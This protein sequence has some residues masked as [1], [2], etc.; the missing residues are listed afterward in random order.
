MHNN[1]STYSRW[2]WIVAILLALGLVLMW[3]TGHGPSSTCCSSNPTAMP[4]AIEAAA[5]SSVVTPIVDSFSFK[6][7]A[8]EFSSV[9]DGSSIA[10]LSLSNQIKALLAEGKD[11]VASGDAN[12]I[13]L[14]GTI[15][16]E[17]AKQQ[18]TE[19][20]QALFGPNINIDNQMLVH[21][22]EAV[23]TATPPELAKFYFETAKA[24]LPSDYA[25]TLEPI[26]NW[27]K[28]NE[29]AKAVIS[30]FHDATGHA[31]RNIK[32]AKR[33]AQSTYDALITAGIDASRI[34]MRKPQEAI[35][36]GSDDEARRVEISIE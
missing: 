23:A 32:L 20:A 1:H 8:S 24:N 33:R 21:V 4:T 13:T 31:D 25:S 19:K 34:E 27:L 3:L 15:S 10:W 11:W 28:A 12:N 26:I 9:G 18:T 35:G 36:S 14:T 2:T 7:N 16:T 17:L 6:A 29:S 5:P 30:G 22:D